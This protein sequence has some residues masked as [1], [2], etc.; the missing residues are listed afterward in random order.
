MKARVADVVPV[1]VAALVHKD[2][3]DV[4]F[5]LADGIVH[6]RKVTVVDKSGSDALV[7]SGLTS[8]DEVVVSS[9][10]TLK[11]GQKAAQ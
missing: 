1:P 6:E 11:D 8:G 3:G 4:V 9:P 10:E 7:G 2:G 5:V